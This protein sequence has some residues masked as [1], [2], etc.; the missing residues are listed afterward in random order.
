MFLE[1]KKAKKRAPRGGVVN[2]VFSQKIQN[3]K[4]PPLTSLSISNIEYI[5]I[6]YLIA[7]GFGV[8][9]FSGLLGIGGAFI[10]NPSLIYLI[11][12]PTSVA[13]E[14]SLFQTIFV[15]G[16]GGLIHFFKGNVDFAL[17]ACVL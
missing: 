9:I 1:S 17:V 2:T 4:I 11:G 16:Y 8:G 3:A 15:S 7:L 10:M 14:T 12:V 5:S 6:G 13:I